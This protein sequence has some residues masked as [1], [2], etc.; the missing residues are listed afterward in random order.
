MVCACAGAWRTGV[1]IA[2][3]NVLSVV[4]LLYLF[5]VHA[6]T[7]ERTCLLLRP[8]AGV[9]CPNDD[10]QVGVGRVDLGATQDGLGMQGIKCKCPACDHMVEHG[11]C[12]VLACPD[13]TNAQA[14]SPV[15]R[16]CCLVAAQQR[17]RIQQGG[18]GLRMWACARPAT[19]HWRTQ[20]RRIMRSLAKQTWPWRR[21]DSSSRW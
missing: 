16:Q 14:W 6:V 9:L 17:C 20:T 15:G 2:K 13:A 4:F 5:L 11:V 1:R 18:Q 12:K 21:V 19:P 7:Y 3:R 10:G 8:S